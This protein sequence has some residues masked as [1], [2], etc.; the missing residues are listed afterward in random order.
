MTTKPP[1]TF[2]MVWPASMLANSRIDRLNG[3]MK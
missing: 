3:R 1:D 2:S